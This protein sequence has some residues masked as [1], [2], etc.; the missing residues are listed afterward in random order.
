MHQVWYVDLS[1]T[2]CCFSMTVVSFVLVSKI[3]SAPSPRMRLRHLDHLYLLLSWWNLSIESNRFISK[4]DSDAIY[5]S[6]PARKR[7][8]NSGLHQESISIK[9]GGSFLD[10]RLGQLVSILDTH[11]AH[12]NILTSQRGGTIILFYTWLV[13]ERDYIRFVFV[14]TRGNVQAQLTGSI[15]VL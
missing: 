8:P 3:Y 4:N 7:M 11:Q 12:P 9:T 2:Q 14:F 13:I 6:V 1:R 5:H 10:L 15:W